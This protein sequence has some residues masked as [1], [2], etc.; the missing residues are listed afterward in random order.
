[1]NGPVRLPCTTNSTTRPIS[2][3]QWDKAETP[4]ERL[5][6]VRGRGD[7]LE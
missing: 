5:A 2:E 3:A 1:M 7:I 6:V 4:H